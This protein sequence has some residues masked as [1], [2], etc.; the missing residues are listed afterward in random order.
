MKSWEKEVFFMPL[1][2]HYLFCFTACFWE[3]ILCVVLKQLSCENKCRKYPG[4]LQCFFKNQITKYK[5][6]PFLTDVCKLLQYSSWNDLKIREYWLID[7]LIDWIKF[8]ALS[9]IFQPIHVHVTCTCMGTF[10][11]IQSCCVGMLHVSVLILM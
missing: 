2:L 10:W 6:H 5:S 4:T 7:W 3:S 11:T 9:A 1:M 8:Y